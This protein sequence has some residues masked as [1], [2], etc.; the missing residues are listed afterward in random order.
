VPDRS[1]AT[2]LYIGG[3][4]RSGSTLLAYLLGQLDGYVVAG[5]LKYVWQN[6]VKDNELC[7]C[8]VPFSDCPFWQDVGQAAFGGWN[9][10]DVDDVLALQSRVTSARSVLARLAHRKASPDFARLSLL[11]RLLYQ[12]ILDVSGGRVVVDT[13]KTPV[14]ALMLASSPGIDCRVIHL[15][16]DS[17]GVAFSWAKTGIRLPQIVNREALML[18][19]SPLYIA[20]RWVYGN[21]FFEL[22]RATTPTARLRYEDLTNAP[23]EHVERALNNCGILGGGEAVSIPDSRSVELGTLHTLGGN[24]MRFERGSAPIKRDEAWRR[25]LP[26]GARRAVT[27]VTWPLLLGYGYLGPRSG[28][29][30]RSVSA[31]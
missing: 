13:S 18:D 5:E 16:R 2:V 1:S 26:R 25:E 30:A 8:G 23:E 19:Y 28:E 7:G 4:G 20:P 9:E 17:R 14:E 27:A 11:L 15:V 6:G 31:T 24:P 10:V 21:L 29:P 12:A 22:L 3:F